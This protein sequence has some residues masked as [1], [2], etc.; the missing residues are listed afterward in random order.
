M[1]ATYHQVRRGLEEAAQEMMAAGNVVHAM[2]LE[3]LA[4]DGQVVC[5]LTNRINAKTNLKGA[6]K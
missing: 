6:S 4:N 1:S 5:S 3:N 2:F